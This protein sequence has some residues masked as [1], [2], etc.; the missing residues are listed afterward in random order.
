MRDLDFMD[1]IRNHL[2]LIVDQDEAVLI[3]ANIGQ[4]AEKVLD[5]I[6][7]VIEL[8][9]TQNC[10]TYTWTH[11]SY[12]CMSASCARGTRAT[13]TAKYYPDSEL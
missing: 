1:Q 10:S 3:D 7:E 5:K 2:Y 4:A 12:W 13:G 11:G 8:D 6:E 9:N